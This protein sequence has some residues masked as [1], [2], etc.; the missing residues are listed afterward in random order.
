M[1]ISLSFRADSCP[2]RQPRSYPYGI[3]YPLRPND[4]GV[5]DRV[6][7]TLMTGLR[8]LVTDMNPPP[9]TTTRPAA[10]APMSENDRNLSKGRTRC[11]QETPHASPGTDP[12]GLTRTGPRTRSSTATAHTNGARRPT[13]TGRE[14]CQP[15]HAHAT[16]LPMSA[17]R[18]A[19]S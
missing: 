5:L 4:I 7:D 17:C 8:S 6:A 18:Q 1:L 3:T 16:Q 9:S 19:R 14:P 10:A 13:A 11:P 12:N 15:P 2:S